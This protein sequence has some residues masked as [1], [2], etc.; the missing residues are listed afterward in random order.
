MS[1]FLDV[2]TPEILFKVAVQSPQLWTALQ[3]T[4]RHCRASLEPYRNEAISAWTTHIAWTPHIQTSDMAHWNEYTGLWCRGL[5][6]K[7][8]HSIRLNGKLHCE[9]EPAIRLQFSGTYVNDEE[10]DVE[11]E[12]Y[13]IQGLRHRSDGPAFTRVV[14]NKRGKIIEILEDYWEQGQRHRS[15]APAT[16]CWTHKYN[17]CTASYF[18][19]GRWLRYEDNVDKISIW[20]IDQ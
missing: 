13:W 4:C 19:H 9:D 8:G 6:L 17:G 14:K 20:D 10:V 18:E 7:Y 3:Q 5:E 1:S 15:G 12:E 11:C 16:I 2:F